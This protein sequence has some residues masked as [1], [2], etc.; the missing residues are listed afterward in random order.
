MKHKL[1][2]F[3]LSFTAY[4]SPMLMII[5]ILT[6]HWLFSKEK[7]IYHRGILSDLVKTTNTN[8]T[9][10]RYNRYSPPEDFTEAKYGLFRMCR[11]TGYLILTT[12]AK[13]Q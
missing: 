13:K 2:F 7:I 4:V 6:N 9:T 10:T 11:T 12:T 3:G 5:S 1:L 8:I